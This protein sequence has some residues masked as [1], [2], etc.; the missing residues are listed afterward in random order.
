L[1]ATTPE[2]D[3]AALTAPDT[4]RLQRILPGPPERIWAYLTESEMRRKWLAAGEMEMRVGAT[5]ELAW[6][7]DELTEPSGK[8]PDGFGTE[9][10]MQSRITELD[11]PHRI[12]FTWDDS[13]DVSFQLEP[14]GKNVLLTVIHRHIPNRGSML[15]VGA[16]WHTHLDLL[17]ARIS[18]ARTEPYWDGWSRL[19]NAYDR[20]LPA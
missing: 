13:S 11:P 7:F 4:V 17:V 9:H 3:Y 10:R 5:F 6:H 16:G 8:R 2:S 19:K 1:N 18:G 15:M 20:R 14:Q 12:S